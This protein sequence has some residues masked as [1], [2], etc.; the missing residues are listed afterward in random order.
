LTIEQVWGS[1]PTRGYFPLI[2]REVERVLIGS[3]DPIIHY[4]TTVV[5]KLLIISP[6]FFNQRR[7]FGK[8]SRGP[9]GSDVSPIFLVGAWRRL[10]PGKE[11]GVRIAA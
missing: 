3:I 9:A 2:R 6:F 11:S 10:G 5:N 7:L 8:P 4:F 1:V